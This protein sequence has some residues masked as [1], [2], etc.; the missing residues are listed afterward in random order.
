MGLV[1]MVVTAVA[2][3]INSRL[4][5]L[6]L[7]IAAAYYMLATKGSVYERLLKLIVYATPY[8]TFSIFGDR[9]RLSVC[10][11]AVAV[12]CVLLTL[13]SLKRGA[14]VSVG[15]T[16]KLLLFLIFLAAYSFSVLWG[17][18]TRKE[19]VFTTYQ[20]VILAYLVFIIPI[21]R[22][23]ELSDVDTEALMKL[24]VRGI[25]AVTITLYIQYV[26]DQ[27]LGIRLGE[28]Y[29]YN[30]DR[31]IYNVYFYA[32]SV[33][34]LYLSIGMLYYFIEYI[35]KK[36][37]KD[38]VWLAIFAGAVWINNSRTGLGCF[39]VCAVLYC[40]RHLKQIVSSIRVTV[41]LILVAVV[42]LYIVQYMLTSRT[43][44]EGIADD[45][46]RSE[47]IVEAFKLLPNYIFSGIGGG[48]VDYRM[49]SIG[50]TI[51]NFIMAYLIQFGVLGGLAVNSLLISPVF[52]WKKQNWYYLCCVLV[53]GLFF[54][55]WQN[56]LY[57]VPVYILFLLEDGKR[58]TM[59][60]YG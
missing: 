55:N 36:S 12:L 57:I 49:S 8:Y 16:I 60:M 4:G 1:V 40:L 14:K 29:E 43:G 26:A 21:S 20:L 45:N 13:N 15:A 17:S 7:L 10:I 34:S 54:A 38:I 5:A 51:H 42:G 28:V 39:A 11:I 6:L 9:Q 24:F 2:Y 35:N 59:E 41:V 44:L 31:V 30:S 22:N 53:G 33:L 47:Q 18:Y 3:M 52:E 32:K 19:T 56:V 46:G 25:C 23:E 27:L 50:V 48:E 37:I 58:H